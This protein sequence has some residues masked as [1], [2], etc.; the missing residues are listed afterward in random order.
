[1]AGGVTPFGGRNGVL[2]YRKTWW[3]EKVMKLSYRDIVRGKTP[4][5][6]LVLEAGDT[7]V[8]H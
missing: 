5:D 1:M 6:N 4:D 7:I 8:V 3:G 2:I